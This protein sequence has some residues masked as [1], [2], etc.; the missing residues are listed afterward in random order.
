MKKQITE[1]D[2]QLLFDDVSFVILDAKETLSKIITSNIVYVYWQIGCRINKQILKNKRADYVKQ[3]VAALSR[4]L[5]AEF[6]R[7]YEEKKLRRMMQFAMQHSKNQVN[8]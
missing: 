7:S 5:T 1:T 8:K 6:G 4:Q 2:D 3:I